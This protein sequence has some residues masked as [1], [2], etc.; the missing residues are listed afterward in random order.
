V[1]YPAGGLAKA[2]FVARYISGDVT[3]EQS[4]SV[5]ASDVIVVIPTAWQGTLSTPKPQDQVPVPSTIP[6]PTTTTIP[7]TTVPATT[8]T[9]IGDVPQAPPGVSC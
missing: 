7:T 1:E 4:D 3:F 5:T 9:A 6:A 8:T 2:R